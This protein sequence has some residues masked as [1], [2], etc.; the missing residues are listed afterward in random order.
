MSA[1]EG[2]IAWAAVQDNLA[3][4]EQGEELLE[5]LD[6]VLY[7]RREAACFDSSIGGHVR[8]VLEHYTS[9]LGGLG[10]GVVSYEARARD[11]RIENEPAHAARHLREIKGR[12]AKLA[13]QE[14]NRRVLVRSEVARGDETEP[15]ADSCALREL[16]FLLS[17][18]IHHFALVGVICKLAGLETPKD[19]GVAPS[20]LRHRLRLAAEA[21]GSAGSSPICAR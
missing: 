5:S 14:E 4:L 13:E 12:L 19:F 10:A 6:A 15:W 18:T 16:E 1:R 7:A 3:A 11:A 8:H 2:L 20:T 17:H 9:F 21:A